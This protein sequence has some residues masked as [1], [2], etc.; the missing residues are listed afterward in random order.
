MAPHRSRDSVATIAAL[1]TATAKQT[2]F[3]LRRREASDAQATLRVEPSPGATPRRG[4][5]QVRQGRSIAWPSGNS[6]PTGVAA[7]TATISSG[8]GPTL[9]T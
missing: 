7:S 9:N 8:S 4:Q 1:G 6:V 2:M 3:I 5:G